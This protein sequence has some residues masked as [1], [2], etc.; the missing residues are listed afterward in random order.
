VGG[1]VE[2]RRGRGKG[3]GRWLD[4]FTSNPPF[5]RAKLWAEITLYKIRTEAFLSI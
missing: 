4:A 1:G 5:L 2:R 3:G